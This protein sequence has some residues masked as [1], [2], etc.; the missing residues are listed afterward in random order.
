MAERYKLPG[1][2]GLRKLQ[3]ADPRHP[4]WALQWRGM[5]WAKIVDFSPPAV[6]GI[7]TLD[8]EMVEFAEDMGGK[9]ID[10]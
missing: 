5:D 7:A 9:P 1:E 8:A 4:S 3:T 2:W 10:D 6:N